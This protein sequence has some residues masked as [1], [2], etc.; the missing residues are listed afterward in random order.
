M[1]R[2]SAPESMISALGVKNE[3]TVLGKIADIR[4][5]AMPKASDIFIPIEAILATEARSRL[6]QYCAARTRMVPSI[7]PLNI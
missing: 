5:T 6:P 2:Y 3:M 7:P 1:P 4:L